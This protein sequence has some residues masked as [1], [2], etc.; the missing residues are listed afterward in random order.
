MQWRSF[1]ASLI[2]EVEVR[3]IFVAM[4]SSYCGR[5][6]K[7][8]RSMQME[9]FMRLLLSMREEMGRRKKDSIPPRFILH[10]MSHPLRGAP[11]SSGCLYIAYQKQH[12]N[13]KIKTSGHTLNAHYPCSLPTFPFTITLLCGIARCCCVSVDCSLGNSALL[14][15]VMLTWIAMDECH[16]R[17]GGLGSKR[18][19]RRGV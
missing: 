5:G 8:C 16:T 9:W 3:F 12:I 1:G 13:D 17:T 14:F 7:S 19:Q 2:Q 11:T 10:G 4:V 15:V 18:H 6:S